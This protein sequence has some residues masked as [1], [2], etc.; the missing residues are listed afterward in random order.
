[1][2]KAIRAH[3]I[4]KQYEII[5][6]MNA[7][8]SKEEGHEEVKEAKSANYGA[9][10]APLMALGPGI[11]L[12]FEVQRKLIKLFAIIS[13]ISVFMMV[14]YASFGGMSYL[15]T[16]TIWHKVSFGNMGFPEAVCA[17]DLLFSDADKV[18]MFARC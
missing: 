12:Y 8:A 13:L 15:E 6:S 18:E 4:K 2:M 14:I 1:M 16:Q 17:K 3:L 11:H 9:D 5:D 10:F 7:K